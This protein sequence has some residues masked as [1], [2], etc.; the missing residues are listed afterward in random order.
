MRNVRKPTH[1][2]AFEEATSGK[3]FAEHGIIRTRSLRALQ[4]TGG[5]S[6]PH[7]LAIEMESKKEMPRIINR[8]ETNAAGKNPVGKYNMNEDARV[9]TVHFLRIST[10]YHMIFLIL[11]TYIEVSR[12]LQMSITLHLQLIQN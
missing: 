3:S 8:V 6:T 5:A 9:P 1:C 11:Q 10:S 2:V 4:V 12:L 7:Y